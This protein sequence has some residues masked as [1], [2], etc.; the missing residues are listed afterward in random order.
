MTNQSLKQL[1]LYMKLMLYYISLVL[2][3]LI[4]QEH[5]A[6]MAFSYQPQVETFQG[7]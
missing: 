1:V 5:W 6:Q 7:M 2:D 4:Q 3:F